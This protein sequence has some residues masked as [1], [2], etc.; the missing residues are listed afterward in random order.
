MGDELDAIR[1]KRLQELQQQKQ[2]PNAGDVEKQKNEQEIAKNSILAQVMD[3][4]AFARLS[5]LAAAKPDKAKTVESIIINMARMGQI[6]SK[7][8]D[9]DLRGLL[10]R[11]SDTK[12]NT[13]VKYNRR[14]IDSDDED[15]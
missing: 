3:Q 2:L 14:K 4:S 10:S 6:R 12:T 11:I 5:N 13:T 15:E 8:S 9:E 1:A 7:M